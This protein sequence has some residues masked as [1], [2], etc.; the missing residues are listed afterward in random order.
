MDMFNRAINENKEYKCSMTPVPEDKASI[1][2]INYKKQF[3]YNPSTKQLE[4][5]CTWTGFIDAKK[6]DDTNKNY[7]CKELIITL[8]DPPKSLVR[9]GYVLPIQKPEPE[10]IEF[11]PSDAKSEQMLLKLPDHMK[12]LLKRIGIINELEREL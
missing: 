6:D 7:D 10:P 9:C 8:T 1:R 2:G 11:N 4:F 5:V 3:R 12:E